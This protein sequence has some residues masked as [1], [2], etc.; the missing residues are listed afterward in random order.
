[1][2][3]QELNNDLKEL[4]KNLIPELNRLTIKYMTGIDKKS[5]LAKSVG[6]S[7][8]KDGINMKANNYW[9]YA[10]KGRRARTAKVPISALV[11]YIKRYNITPR[12]GQ[13]INQLAFA[14]QTSIYK[15]GINPKNYAD[16]V[17]D[18]VSDLTEETLSRELLDEL[19]DNIVE[20]CQT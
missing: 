9:Y 19:A 4:L 5:D 15:Q 20:L 8:T 13:T 6:Y 2:L 16:K 12:A 18:A 7:V 14:I 11:D 10:S 17:I 3:E 1:M